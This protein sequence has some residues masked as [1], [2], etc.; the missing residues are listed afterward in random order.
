MLFGGWPSSVKATF[1]AT[2]M[3]GHW[4]LWRA[5]FKHSPVNITST[6]LIHHLKY[7]VTSKLKTGVDCVSIISAI[8]IITY[9]SFL[10][11]TCLL[12]VFTNLIPRKLGCWEKLKE[13]FTTKHVNDLM[14][15]TI[16]R[17]KLCWVFY[18]I[19]GG[20]TKDFLLQNTTGMAETWQQSKQITTEASAHGSAARPERINWL[21]SS[22]YL[23]ESHTVP[24]SLP[25][26]GRLI[27]SVEVTRGLP[28]V[29][30]TAQACALYEARIRYG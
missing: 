4:W 20:L 25:A 22:G 14:L 23:N 13:H 27:S 8:W 15:C 3:S 19:Y 1:S 11:I 26:S 12:Y 28:T 18:N 24:D 6:Q 2:L 9:H 21:I 30:D 10:Y 7:T 5:A 29:A 17:N 16:R